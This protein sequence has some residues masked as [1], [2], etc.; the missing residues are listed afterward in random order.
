[1]LANWGAAAV[2]P[3]SPASCKTP[4]PEELAVGNW[5]AVAMPVRPLKAGCAQVGAPDVVA[6]TYWLAE[7]EPRPAPVTGVAGVQDVPL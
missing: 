7:Q 4:N 3:R 2:P 5:V 6:V 1:M